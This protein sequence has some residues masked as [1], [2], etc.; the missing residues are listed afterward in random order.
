MNQRKINNDVNYHEWH[1]KNENAIHFAT[2]INHKD[3]KGVKIKSFPHESWL[4]IIIHPMD[5]I[6]SQ[7]HNWFI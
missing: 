5:F 4:G 1:R 2:T 7:I 6:D 3:R